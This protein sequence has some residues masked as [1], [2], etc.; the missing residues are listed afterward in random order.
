MARRWRAEKE[1]RQRRPRLRESLIAT[2]RWL[3]DRS[4]HSETRTADFSVV[5]RERYR[6]SWCAFPI[7]CAYNEQSRAF[8]SNSSSCNIMHI[9]T[10][11]RALLGSRNTNTGLEF[12]F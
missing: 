9:Y 1:Q 2:R 12:L 5:A 8:N 3:R 10:C 6:R 11:L 7:S 4:I